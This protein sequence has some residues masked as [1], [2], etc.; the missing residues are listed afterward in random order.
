MW[1]QDDGDFGIEEGMYAMPDEI[2]AVNIPETPSNLFHRFTSLDP[3]KMSSSYG[4]DLYEEALNYV[5][6]HRP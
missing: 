6:V 4:I 1:L 3:M 5:H 2:A